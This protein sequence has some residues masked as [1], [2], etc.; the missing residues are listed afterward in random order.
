MTR[1]PPRGGALKVLLFLTGTPDHISESLRY[2]FD[3]ERFA[4]DLFIGDYYYDSGFVFCTN[5]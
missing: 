2:Y 5:C 3:V 4:R 1:P